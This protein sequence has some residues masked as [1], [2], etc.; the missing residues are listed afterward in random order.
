MNEIKEELEQLST[1]A[2]QFILANYLGYDD[3]LAQILSHQVKTLL[4]SKGNQY[5]VYRYA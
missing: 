1:D 5:D 4:S 2:Q 3:G